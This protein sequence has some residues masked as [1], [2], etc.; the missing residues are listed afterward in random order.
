M[1]SYHFQ[2]KW[3]SFSTEYFSLR[4]CIVFSHKWFIIFL[5]SVIN[6]I[7]AENYCGI[8]TNKPKRWVQTFERH[9]LFVVSIIIIAL[10]KQ[11]LKCG[12]V[13]SDRSFAAVGC[14]CLHFS[15]TQKVELLKLQ[16]PYWCIASIKSD[17]MAL[18]LLAMW[19]VNDAYFMWVYWD[20]R[21]TLWCHH[22][23]CV[24]NVCICT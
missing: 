8:W 2:L 16:Q 3:R 18:Q 15:S 23:L 13:Y 17:Y 7:Q 19:C 22:I 24:N 14:F 12:I 5:F 10:R 21:I 1:S 9:V 4:K 11:T 6:R 20:C